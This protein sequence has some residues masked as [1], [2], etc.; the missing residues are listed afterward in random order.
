[1]MTTS[2]DKIE[3]S[4]SNLTHYMKVLLPRTVQHTHGNVGNSIARGESPQKP[5]G[6]GPR[7]KVNDYAINEATGQLAKPLRQKYTCKDFSKEQIDAAKEK[8]DILDPYD[9]GLIKE[10]KIIYDNDVKRW[11]EQQGIYKIKV[12]KFNE[13]DKAVTCKIR[14]MLGPQTLAR[15]STHKDNASLTADP[16]S[17][18][19]PTNTAYTLIKILH[20]TYASGSTSDTS[21]AFELMFDFK[22]EL[23]DT[24]HETILKLEQA[25]AAALDA[26]T[27]TQGNIKAETIKSL[28][29]IRFWA[30]GAR[31]YPYIL[32]AM[33]R[34]L[35]T[36]PKPGDHLPTTIE[37]NKII[38]D[39][40]KMSTTI[41]SPSPPESA[42]AAA[43]AAQQIVAVATPKK[44]TDK[45]DCKW[46]LEKLGI[47]RQGHLAAICSNN[48]ANAG[49]SRPPPRHPKGGGNPAGHIANA[50]ATANSQPPTA[51]ATAGATDT[52]WQLENAKTQGKYE[53]LFAIMANTNSADDYH[54]STA[55]SVIT[56]GN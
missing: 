9:L 43:F 19:A 24:I 2:S 50:G 48:P 39:E 15:I 35:L 56:Q 55:T 22:S 36:I 23:S 13:N 41:D 5:I 17:D 28:V 51:T 40:F 37:I 26:L 25:C 10:D 11:S 30:R 3:L 21:S 1:M 44:T 34:V 46:C 38:L 18:D 7:P 54:G 49:K 53:A 14:D 45:L 31:N 6:P 16:S 32:R 47:H 42:S 20:D 33:H 52:N 4:H 8:G 12:D 29:M 27:D